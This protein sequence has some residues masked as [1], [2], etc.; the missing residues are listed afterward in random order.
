MPVR[1]YIVEDHAVM[2]ETLRDYLALSPDLVM[3]GEAPDAETASEELEQAGPDVVLVDLSLPGR[4]GLELVEEIR[5]RW[6][7]RC[8]IL[9]G[10]GE[11][12][13]VGRAFA[14]GAQGYVLKGNP[15]DVP[16]AIRRVLDGKIHISE[17]LR[18]KVDFDPASEYAPQDYD[19]GARGA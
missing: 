18:R 8:V 16:L 7:I 5:E 15:R 3:C 13:Y 10:H 14:A 4:S 12:T 2:R 6:R 9:S 19:A 17:S 1:V 11:R